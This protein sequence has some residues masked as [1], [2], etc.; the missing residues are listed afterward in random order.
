V[1]LKNVF[2]VI[3]FVVISLGLAQSLSAQLAIPNSPFLYKP[4]EDYNDCDQD[5]NCFLDATIPNATH[6][7]VP[8]RVRWPRNTTGRLPLIVFSHG[9]EPNE[10]GREINIR[11]GRTLA[12]AGYIVIQMSH[13]WTPEQ[14]IAACVEFGVSENDCP[15]FRMGSLFRPRDA[16]VVL[17]ALD[18]IE[19]NLPGLASR[20]D[21]SNIA[22]VGW[23]YGSITA[24]TL[25]GA[26][27][28]LAPTATDVS[29][30]NPLPK[31]FMGL[32]PQSSSEWG[33]KADSWREMTRPILYITGN[34]DFA[35]NDDPI[36]RR[37]PFASVPRGNKYELFINSVG[38]THDTFNIEGSVE[39]MNIWV[40]T[41][42]LAYLDA[43]LKNQALA[44]AY[45]ISNRLPMYGSQ[46]YVQIQRK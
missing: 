44:G 15:Q 33:F 37:V 11:W 5:N 45:L 26:R 9:G 21:R 38:A 10:N 14:R 30:A 1:V 35:Q 4:V 28:N 29:F 43:S 20:I 19:Q 3:G 8:I 2:L 41:Y 39:I 6:R 18:W 24:Q 36:S 40:A 16:N 32:S 17:G 12:K 27:L 31:V 13:F 25:N 42:A 34:G 7:D 23:S 22:V 46:K